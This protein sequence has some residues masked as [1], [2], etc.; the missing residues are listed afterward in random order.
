MRVAHVSVASLYGEHSDL[1]D[2][3]TRPALLSATPSASCLSARKFLVELSR[4]TR[5]TRARGTEARRGVQACVATKMSTRA[6]R[7][8]SQVHDRRGWI[9]MG[10]IM[11]GVRSALRLFFFFWQLQ[12]STNQNALEWRLKKRKKKLIQIR[13]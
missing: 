4:R 8:D 5:G 9:G 12:S 13:S 1:A 6:T 11:D 2:S 3:S 10:A 7:V